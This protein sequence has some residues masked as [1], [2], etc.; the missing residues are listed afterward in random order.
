MFSLGNQQVLVVSSNA[1]LKNIQTL[2]NAQTVNFANV[3]TTQINAQPVATASTIA[4]LQGVKI[5]GKPITI[6][7]PMQ[8]VGTPKTVT[9]SK[10][11]VSHLVVTHGAF[12]YNV[13]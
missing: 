1:G 13:T 10:N 2:T 8:V 11:T 5:G 4:G 12:T 9:L 6:S 3:K 7:M